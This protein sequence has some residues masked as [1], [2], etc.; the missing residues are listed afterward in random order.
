MC[1]ISGVIRF[2]TAPIK[3]EMLTQLMLSM[4]N[5]GMDASG[6]ALVNNGRIEICKA[7][8]SAWR[9]TSSKMYA[10]FLEEHLREDTK[11]ALCHT[12]ACTKGDPRDAVNNHP[13]FAGNCAVVHNGVVRNDDK[14]F[15]EHKL[16]RKAEVDTD[17][18]RAIVDRYGLTSQAVEKLQEL[19]GSVASIIVS[20]EEPEKVLLLRYS[21]PLI[22]AMS[23]D[24][25]MFMASEKHAIHVAARPWVKRRGVWLKPVR[26]P[27]DWATFPDGSAWLFGPEELEWHRSFRLQKWAPPSQSNTKPETAKPAV[28]EVKS[29][30]SYIECRRCQAWTKVDTSPETTDMDNLLCGKCGCLADT[31]EPIGGDFDGGRILM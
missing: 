13:V 7:D 24:D 31:P 23:S 20:N 17:V 30:I 3:A 22:V 25:L 8:E 11:I 10:S 2:G 15:A 12:R 21:N 18:I 9:F 16:E 29:Y 26:A 14:I 1:S 5:R 6:V 4:E 27:L 28:A 19:E